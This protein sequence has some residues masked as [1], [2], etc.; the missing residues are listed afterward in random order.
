MNQIRSLFTIFTILISTG[1]VYSFPILQEIDYQMK[2]NGIIFE[3]NFSSEMPINYASG[4]YSETEWFYITFLNTAIDSTQFPEI[5]KSQF[6]K[7]FQ[8]D[9][10]GESVQVSLKLSIAPEAQEFYQKSND[11]QLYLSLRSKMPLFAT[12]SAPDKKAIQNIPTKF[13][14]SDFEIPEQNKAIITMGYILGFSFTIAGT[15]QEDSKNSVNWKLPVGIGI[16]AGIYV[17]DKY[18]NSSNSISLENLEEDN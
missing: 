12:V 15:I 16:I 9:V 18:F 7:D 8:I 3:F 1:L 13:S 14:E 10:V 11:A 2:D 17:Y 4:W 6:V 5:E